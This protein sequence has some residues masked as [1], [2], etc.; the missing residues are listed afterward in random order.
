MRIKKITVIVLSAALICQMNTFTFAKTPTPSS[1]STPLPLGMHGMQLTEQQLKDKQDLSAMISDMKKSKAGEDYS[2]RRVY[3]TCDDRDSAEMIADCYGADLTDY[4]YGVGVIELDDMAESAGEMKVSDIV[5]L[6]A[7]MTND[8]PAVYPDYKHYTLDSRTGEAE[9]V[10]PVNDPSYKIQWAHS[11]AGT[12][13]AWAE[14]ITGSGVTVAVVDTGVDHNHED[15]MANLI[16]GYNAVKCREGDYDDTDYSNDAG[17]GTHVAGIIGAVKDNEAGGAGIAPDVSIMPVRV[18]EKE[19]DYEYEEWGLVAYT[20][21]IIRGINYAAEHGADIINMSL[22]N[23]VSEKPYERALQRA[24]REGVIAVCSAGND[25]N[26]SLEYP[27]AYD[28]TISVAALS[29]AP[30]EVG[31]EAEYYSYYDEDYDEEYVS[32]VLGNYD[33]SDGA[34]LSKFT[35][36]GSTVDIA[37]PGSAIYSTMLNDQYGYMNGTS[38]AAPVVSGAAALILQSRPRLL[39]SRSAS[40]TEI[41]RKILR[42]SAKQEIYEDTEDPR[43]EDGWFGIVLWNRGY[44]DRGLDIAAAVETG[45]AA[46]EL[47]APIM[48]EYSESY[49]SRNLLSGEGKAL[50]IIN[51]NEMG[52]I[53]Y[54]TDGSNPDPESAQLYSDAEGV[55]LNFS[56]RLNLKAVVVYRD[57]VSPVLEYTQNFK[58]VPES[59]SVNDIGVLKGKKAVLKVQGYPEYATL[60]DI[61]WEDSENFRVKKSRGIYTIRSIAESD[62]EVI[63]GSAA[64]PNGT[65]I[66]VSVAA[67]TIT[68][69]ASGLDAAKK[70]TMTAV[71]EMSDVTREK[72]A[73]QNVREKTI[74]LSDYITC[75]SGSGDYIYK[76]S[77]PAVADVDT[78]GIVTAH[79]AGSAVITITANDGSGKKAKCRVS[80][81]TPVVSINRIITSTGFDSVELDYG[82]ALPIA[83]GGRIKLTTSLNDYDTLGKKYSKPSNSKIEWSIEGET[84]GAQISPKGVLKMTWDEDMVSQAAE[85]G[86]E[87]KVVARAADGFGA[88]SSIMFKIYNRHDGFGFNPGT[89]RSF[90]M[91]LGESYDNPLGYGIDICDGEYKY[92]NYKVIMSRDDMLLFFTD[93][94]GDECV[95]PLKK[96][97]VKVTYL[98]PDGSGMKLSQTI[99]VR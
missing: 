63:S 57:V 85:E 31:G 21:V 10:Y 7:D 34:I 17:H 70:I 40:R 80:V 87:I 38:M 15:L 12:E 66:P 82:G 97:K 92:D 44:M 73:E 83:R 16:G 67:R 56:G 42:E 11:F 6:S 22:G 49:D 20:N 86:C 94:Y 91:K 35:N 53:Y 23:T 76:S 28:C 95:Q 84:Y 88:Q 61:K 96:G 78:N 71:T 50:H 13:S 75:E 32:E 26:D 55:K 46:D 93:N 3:F 29:P 4:E 65:V 43:Y 47:D 68:A 59:I 62:G 69:A 19:Y 27:A 36:T 89:K 14:G 98:V 60:P 77:K 30:Y 24:A 45:M 74:D 72:L 52:D 48:E 8:L 58:A 37:A 33:P 90:T 54:T 51:P 41:V 25:A 64:A 1:N 79:K 5:E 2:D 99:F 9:P 39:E 18:F 81:I